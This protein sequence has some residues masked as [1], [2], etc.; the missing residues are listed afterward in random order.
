M[1]L[2]ILL[3]FLSLALVL[4]SL[5]LWKRA[6]AKAS[7]EREARFSKP[8]SDSLLAFQQKRYADAEAI[9]ASLLQE[10]E[11]DSPG[12]VNEASVL[13]GLGAVTLLQ[14]RDAE[15]EAYYKRAIEIRKKLLR[16]DDP[17]LISSLTGLSQ[18]LR[19]EGH[20]TE[21]DQYNRE[22]LAIYR[23]HP[24]TYRGDFAMCQLNAGYFAFERRQL[25][26][27]Q[28]LLAEAV[29]NFERYEGPASPHLA[30]AATTLAELYED[31]GKYSES[32]ALYKKALAIQEAQLS[33]DD[34][35]L[36]R[37]LDGLADVLF[38]QGKSSEAA[39]LRSRSR[40][41]YEAAGPSQ[42][43]SEAVL[44]N[45]RG[46]SRADEGK[47]REAESLYKQAVQADEAKYGPDHPKIA[48]DLSFLAGLYR[49]EN[50]FPI[51]K[52]EPLFERMLAIR[53]KN[54]GPDS[55]E[56]ASTVSG[57]ALLYFFEKK[58]GRCESFAERALTIQQRV[59][60]H[61]GLEVSTTLNRLGVCQRDLNKLDQAEV[62]LSRA[63]AIREKYLPSDDH[64]IAIS[65]QNLASVYRAQGHVE[66]AT[67]LLKS[68]RGTRG[69]TGEN[70]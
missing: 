54:F 32:E 2:R 25:E 34:A 53:E 69:K 62:S 49:D 24:E 60:G 16:P 45:R 10:T 46:Q 66:K 17:E 3:G 4:G 8:F 22:L 15:A 33:P 67:L 47:Y 59:F 44:L 39:I 18:A 29:G 19:N 35:E 50:G 9:L 13:H 58:Y 42:T 56:T 14:H 52:A 31:E 6:Q 27:A 43:I 26:E 38:N 21:A 12:S 40:A 7:L 5:A 61:E 48:D 57:M 36:G 28:K 23:Q 65:V 37:T 20:D 70:E 51:E 55:P 68:P 1:R 30:L 64:R 11:R 41:I 63:L